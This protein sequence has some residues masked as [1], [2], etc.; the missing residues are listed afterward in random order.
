MEEQAIV[1]APDVEEMLVL[2]RLLHNM[3]GP[4][5]E[6]QWEHILHSWCTIQSKVCSLIIDG[7]N[8][9]NTGSINLINK[10]KLPTI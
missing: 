9:T 3:E 7:G 10:L 5:E 4:Q 6:D 2:R 8:G 1:L